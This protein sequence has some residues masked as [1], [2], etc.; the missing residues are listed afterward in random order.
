MGYCLMIQFYPTPF[1]SCLERCGVVYDIL[2]EY[3]QMRAEIEVAN[4]VN[5]VNGDIHPGGKLGAGK[6]GGFVGIRFG[7][8]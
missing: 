1:L 3:V 7:L 5:E 4:E 8:A 2:M 6:E